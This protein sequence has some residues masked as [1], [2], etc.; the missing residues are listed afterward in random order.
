VEIGGGDDENACK[1][2]WGSLHPSGFNVTMCDGSVQFISES[3]DIF[4]FGMMS[5]IANG[6]IIPQQ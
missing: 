2:S 6:E 5:T 3:I 1:R 4:V